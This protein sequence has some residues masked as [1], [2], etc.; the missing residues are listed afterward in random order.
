M[1]MTVY[2]VRRGNRIALGSCCFIL[3]QTETCCLS[4]VE[5]SIIKMKTRKKIISFQIGRAKPSLTNF[6]Q[7]SLMEGKAL[8]FLGTRNT[9]QFTKKHYCITLIQAR[10]DRNLCIN[11]N[12]SHCQKVMKPTWTRQPP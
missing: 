9:D 8:S 5:T 3:F 4:L 2:L 10:K 1:I 11:P 7:K 6:E 12:H